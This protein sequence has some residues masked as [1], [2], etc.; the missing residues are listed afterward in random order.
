M[1]IFELCR[2]SPTQKCKSDAEIKAWM[3]KKYIVTL[4]NEKKFL[5]HDFSE[6]RITLESNLRWYGLS[7]N[8]HV[9][10]VK[11]FTRTEMNLDDSKLNLGSLGTER[12]NGFIISKLPQREMPYDK[13]FM[14][15]ISFELSQQKT[16]YFRRVFSVFDFLR[17]I[18]GLYSAFCSLCAIIISVT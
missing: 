1:A 14:N 4:E 10:Y 13:K 11:Q 7:P 3:N 17:D 8:T 2:P 5:A 18:G 15:A 9:D 16:V 12:D 6:S